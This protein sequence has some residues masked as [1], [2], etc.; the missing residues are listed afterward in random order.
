MA[1]RILLPT[2]MNDYS[3]LTSFSELAAIYFPDEGFLSGVRMSLRIVLTCLSQCLRLINFNYIYCLF[4][5]LLVNYFC[6]SLAIF[7]VYLYSSLY[8]LGI[9][10]LFMNTWQR[11]SPILRAVCPLTWEFL[12]C[13]F[14][15][16]IACSTVFLYTFLPVLLSWHGQNTKGFKCIKYF[17]KEE[18]DIRKQR[19]S[20]GCLLRTLDHNFPL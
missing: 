10:L 16:F 12:T 13:Q 15:V 2:L 8:I 3:F 4:V 9:N 18:T 7:D 20:Q 19:L 11:L 17:I 1:Q 5:F 14:L 6:S